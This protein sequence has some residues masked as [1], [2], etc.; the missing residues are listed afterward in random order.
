MGHTYCSSLYH[1]VF[2]TKERRPWIALDVQSQLWAYMGGIAR[3]QGAKALGVGGMNDHAHLLLSLPSSL[4]VADAMREI[5]S[6]SSRWMRKS[7]GVKTFAWQEGY[8]AFSIGGRDAHDL[9]AYILD[10]EAHHRVQTYQEEFLR[11]LA[12]NDLDYDECYIRG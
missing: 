9:V 1:C 4:T 3:A 6:G 8:G 2:S 5:K 11:L 7:A 10:Q 12:V